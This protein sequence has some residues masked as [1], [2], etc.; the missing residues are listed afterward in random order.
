MHAAHPMFR[1]RAR[2]PL[3]PI[4][5]RSSDRV[6]T[7]DELARRRSGLDADEVAWLQR[8]VGGLAD[9]RRPVL[10]R[11]RAVAA[12]PRRRRVLGRRP[13]A[14]DDRAHGAT[15]TTWSGT[16]LP[17][18]KRPLLDARCATGGWPARATRS[19]ATTC[20]VRVEAIPVRHDGRV[21]AVVARNT[22]LHGRA[23]AQP[24][25]AGVPPDRQRAR[26]DDRRRARSRTPG[27]A[28]T[29]P[30]RRASATASSG[31]TRTG[32]V[33]YASPN[34]QSVYRKLGLAGD[35]A[36]QHLAEI[37]RDR[38]P[39]GC[40]PTRRRSARCSA[41]GCRARPRSATATAVVISGRSRCGRRGR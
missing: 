16:Y 9:R 15:S 36:G 11:P 4:R 6:P 33:V 18:G 5:L 28:P 38:C 14:P 32:R 30:T 31:S 39:R 23:Y 26:A 8:L 34:A 37:T 25:G 10:R 17:R 21:I 19:G 12:G 1:G 29:T 7:L 2:P 3:V 41:A 27:S 24:A 40:G 22:N 35:L 20:P 13:D